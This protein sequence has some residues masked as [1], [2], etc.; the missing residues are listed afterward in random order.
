MTVFTLK[1]WINV[2]SG[3]GGAGSKKGNFRRFYLTNIFQVQ[4]KFIPN[5][6][7][8]HSK[9]IIHKYSSLFLYRLLSTCT[10][11]P[12]SDACYS[13]GSIFILK[14]KIDAT[15]W[16]CNGDSASKLK[17]HFVVIFAIV[18]ADHKTENKPELSWSFL[19]EVEAIRYILFLLSC[20]GAH[21]V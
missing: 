18:D 12:W 15:I 10:N 4:N 19:D 7:Q 8:G 1:T 14:T 16:N 17:E 3:V 2:Y 6:L 13:E 5:M 21:W 20:K 9:Y 11:Q